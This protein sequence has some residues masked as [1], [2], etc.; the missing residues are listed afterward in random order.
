MVKKI[1][2]NLKLKKYSE[3]DWGLIFPKE[4]LDTHEEYLHALETIQIEPELGLVL[5]ERLSKKFPDDNIEAFLALGYYYERKPDVKKCK[6]SYYRAYMI[7]ESV[8]PAEFNANTERL[9]WGIHEN[10]AILRAY[11][12][13]ALQSMFAGNLNKASTLLNFII[14]VNPDDNMGARYLLTEC[15]FLQDKLKQIIELF[16]FYNEDHSPEYYY[17]L[18]LIYYKKFNF[19][20][21]SEYLSLAI[22]YYPRVALELLSGS[23]K[24]PINEY[25]SHSIGTLTGGEVE[26][27][28]FKQ[29]YKR[30]WDETAGSLNYLYHLLPGIKK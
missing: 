19:D 13:W 5:M 29:N 18:G 17:S 25:L 11:F 21:A 2:T 28:E 8:I 30:F 24:F 6:D 7:A 22:D 10:R 20:K 16:E 15:Y 23:K 9:P 4:I 14:R 26:A 1:N 27:Y 3:H 12:N